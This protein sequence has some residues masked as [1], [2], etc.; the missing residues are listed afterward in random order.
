MAKKIIIRFIL[1][2]AIAISSV[3]FFGFLFKLFGRNMEELILLNMTTFLL[4]TFSFMLLSI[5]CSR[6]NT[7]I[8]KCLVYF[9]RGLVALLPVTMFLAALDVITVEEFLIIVCFIVFVS[10]IILF[11]F[12]K[13]KNEINK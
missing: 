9:S 1:V 6:T 13:P 5:R 8:S 11:V 3:Y 12:R 10:L 2:I 4:S 7:L